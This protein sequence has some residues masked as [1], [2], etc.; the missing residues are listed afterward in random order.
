MLTDETRRRIA[1]A[2][3]HEPFNQYAATETGGLAAE[4]EEH[5]G[6][7]L[8]EDLVIFE[9]VDAQNRPVPPGTYGDKLLLTVLF[10]RTQPLIRYELSDSIRLA[11]GPCSCGRSFVLVDGIQGR[12]EDIL[13]LPR[14][15]GNEVLVHPLVFHGILDSLPTSGWQVVQLDRDGTLGRVAVREPRNDGL[16]S[17]DPWRGF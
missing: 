11:V 15:N 8:F 4:C 7:H 5:E 14:A 6:M 17:T 3:G 10:N 1:A 2:W 9:V 16:R 13:R 12:R